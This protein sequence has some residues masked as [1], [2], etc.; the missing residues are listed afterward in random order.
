LL[1]FVLFDVLV[2]FVS[3]SG[4]IEEGNL[5][6]RD[7]MSFFGVYL[8]LAFFCFFIAGFLFFTISVCRLLLV[9][10]G[11]WTLITSSFI[12]DVCF[13]WF[14]AGVHFVGGT[15]WFWLAP[16]LLRHCLGA[17][18]YLLALYVLMTKFWRHQY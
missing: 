14:V 6:T 9:N 5:L 4:P 18:L 7:F 3:V 10:C 13:G 2:T 1:S 11:K 15:S 16:D 8:G 17:G 12:V